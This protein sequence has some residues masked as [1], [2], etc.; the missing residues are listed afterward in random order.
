MNGAL[1]DEISDAQ[2]FYGATN[3]CQALRDG[4]VEE[5]LETL[6]ILGSSKYG[7]MTAATMGYAMTFYCPDVK[8]PFTTMALERGL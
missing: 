5:Q 3:H 7:T 8:E 6:E 1:L 4:K 2:L